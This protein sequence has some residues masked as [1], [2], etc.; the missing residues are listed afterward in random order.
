MH[1]HDT[2]IFFLSF[3]SLCNTQLRT[4]VW[5]IC[6]ISV[7]MPLPFFKSTQHHFCQMKLLFV[8]WICIPLSKRRRRQESILIIT[9]DIFYSTY[10]IS[11]MFFGYIIQNI[12][13]LNQL[14]KL[15]ILTRRILMLNIWMNYNWKERS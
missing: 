13:L 15:W 11:G 4:E 1:L 8:Y 9:C 14:C 5:Q 3:S 2:E 7:C 10:N 6:W 12:G